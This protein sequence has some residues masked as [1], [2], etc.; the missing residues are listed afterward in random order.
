MEEMAGAQELRPKYV[1]QEEAAMVVDLYSRL[2][3]NR[4]KANL[5][6]IADISESLQISEVEAAR[7]LDHVRNAPSAGPTKVENLT[8]YPV[9]YFLGLLAVICS[10]IFAGFFV[11]ASLTNPYWNGGNSGG[12]LLALGWIALWLWHFRRPMLRFF[13]GAGRPGS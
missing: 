13:Q 1:T 2:G 9:L 12:V 7:L 3:E 5:L 4:Q 8:D 10:I 11:F 6:T